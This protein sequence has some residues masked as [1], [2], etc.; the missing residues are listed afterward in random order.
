MSHP[1]IN[2]WGLNLFWYNL[3]Y[4]DKHYSFWLHQ[5]KVLTTFFST[6][7]NYGLIFPLNPLLC[8]RWYV[9]H[10][11]YGLGYNDTHNSKYFR[12]GS[13]EDTRTTSPTSYITRNSTQ[14]M[15]VSKVWLLRYGSWF[16]LS[17]YCFRPRESTLVV[18]L[19]SKKIKKHITSL[20]FES[21]ESYKMLQ[22]I[23]FILSYY[24]I[25]RS[26]NKAAY[27]F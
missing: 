25:Q 17:F 6:Y 22:R 4:T 12:T 1:S 18:R 11:P 26:S 2:R 5:D 10:A 24:Y 8:K 16:V 9:K 27:S 3:W 23:K 20:I 15:Y 21:H 13:F 19:K 14:H 7:I